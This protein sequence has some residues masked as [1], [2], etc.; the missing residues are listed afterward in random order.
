MADRDYFFLVP[1]LSFLVIL[2]LGIYYKLSFL[3]GLAIPFLVLIL[4]AR[5]L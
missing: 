5:F 2:G 4:A 3:I 1:F